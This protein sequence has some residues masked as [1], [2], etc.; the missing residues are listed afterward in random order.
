MAGKIQNED[1]KSSA[2]IIAAGGTDAQL[3]NDDKIYVTANTTNKILKT[4]IEDGDFT[5][6][7]RTINAQ[8][9]VSYTFVLSDGSFAGNNPLV[10]ANNAA[11]QTYTVPPNSSVAFPVGTQIE[12]LQIGAG[13]VSIAPGVGVTINS[14]NGNLSIG[15]QYVGV[16]LIKIATDTWILLGDLVA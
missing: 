10:T 16:A 11:A 6:V 1:I 4:M 7:L 5:K 2:E 8:V 13:T 14:K 15:G 12:L 9:G 3:P